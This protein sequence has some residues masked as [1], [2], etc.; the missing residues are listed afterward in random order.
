MKK[1]DPG[2]SPMGEKYLKSSEVMAATGYSYESLWRLLKAKVVSPQP[3]RGWWTQ[4]QVDELIAYKKK[5]AAAP[6][7]RKGPA[8]KG[9]QFRLR[10]IVI[11]AVVQMQKE[12]GYDSQDAVVEHTVMHAQTCE[13][14]KVGENDLAWGPEATAEKVDLSDL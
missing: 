4:K 13:G 5:V 12:G 3:A 14:F 8:K 7:W 1:A 6:H 2:V 11:D 9:K 10:P